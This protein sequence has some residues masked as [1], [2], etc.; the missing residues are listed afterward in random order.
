MAPKGKIS[1]QKIAK[2]LGVSQ[3][4]VSLALNGR[5]DAISPETYKR[6]W[7]YA[8]ESGYSPKGMSMEQAMAG[9]RP[10]QVGFILRAPLKLYNASNFFSH[11]QHGLHVALEERGLTSVFL[12]SEESLVDQKLAHLLKAAHGCEGVVLLGQVS[13]AFLQTLRNHT[14]N[15]VAVSACYPGICHSVQSNEQQSLSL[16]VGHLVSLG[17]RRIGWLGGNRGMFRHDQRFAAFRQALQDHGLPALESY[18]NIQDGGDRV[19]GAQAARELLKQRRRADFPTAFIAYNGLIARGAINALLQH[20]VAVPGELSIAAVDATRVMEEDDP[21]IT[22]AS[23]NPESLGAEAAKL[24]LEKP[25]SSGS[26][27]DLVVSSSLTV[28]ATTGA[29]AS[30]SSAVR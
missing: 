9:S 15:I 8:V 6:V 30:A 22:S 21:P 13:R 10:R 25:S 29:P 3:A 20:Q 17:H 16:L 4:L 14:Q 1:Q 7:D 2:S 19:E 26:F 11:V 24:L 5:R 23:A 18:W 28:R 27:T 12:G